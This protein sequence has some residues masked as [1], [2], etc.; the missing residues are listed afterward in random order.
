MENDLP[1]KDEAMK[2]I[3]QSVALKETYWN[4]RLK[5][6][7]LAAK[8]NTQEAIG[9]AEKAVQIGKANQDEPTEIEKTE[10]KIAAWKSGKS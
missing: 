8:G 5:A 10:K 3:D 7:M 6:D 9:V 2:W 4:L 1:Q